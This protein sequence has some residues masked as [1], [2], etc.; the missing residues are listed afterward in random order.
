LTYRQGETNA[1]SNPPHAVVCL[2]PT[3]GGES[4]S[5]PWSTWRSFRLHIYGYVSCRNMFTFCLADNNTIRPAVELSHSSQSRLEWA[6]G[7]PAKLRPHSYELSWNATG[8]RLL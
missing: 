5:Q 8:N 1:L 4:S 2:P 3:K 6:T 7:R